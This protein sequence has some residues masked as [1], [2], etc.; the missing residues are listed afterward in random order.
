MY[1]NHLV[2]NKRDAVFLSCRPTRWEKDGFYDRVSAVWRRRKKGWTRRQFSAVKIPPT[3]KRIKYFFISILNPPVQYLIA[4]KLEVIQVHM[5]LRNTKEAAHR[6]ISFRIEK[7][8]NK[9]LK[10][11]VEA[12]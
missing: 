1:V 12:E 2:E 3:S 11:W 4:Q 8:E 6:S 10:K 9:S 7:F 5:A